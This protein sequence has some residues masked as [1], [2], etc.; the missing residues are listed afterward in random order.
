[1]CGWVPHQFYV[2]SLSSSSFVLFFFHLVLF[3]SFPTNSF[4]C[5]LI[6]LLLSFDLVESLEKSHTHT[7]M[8]TW[9]TRG[10]QA[11]SLARCYYIN[12]SFSFSIQ[13][14]STFST[15]CFSFIWFFNP[16]LKSPKIQWAW[17]IHK[18]RLIYFDKLSPW[19]PTAPHQL[20]ASNAISPKQNELNG[21]HLVEIIFDWYDSWRTREREKSMTFNL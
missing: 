2:V 9:P 21:I 1:M 6:G 10:Q 14:Q 16:F 19:F 17:G 7:T 11:H 18:G 4:R 5:P 3:S 15:K 12:V 13:V 20:L 8:C